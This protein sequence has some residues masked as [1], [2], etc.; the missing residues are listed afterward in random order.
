M[1]RAIAEAA[2]RAAGTAA[3]PCRAGAGPGR[4]FRRRARPR[5]AILPGKRGQEPP[6][7][8]QIQSLGRTA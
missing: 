6:L 8:Q 5:P 1:V 4:G 3:A 7:A 2:R